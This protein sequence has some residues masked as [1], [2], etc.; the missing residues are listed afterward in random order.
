MRA[1]LLSLFLCT[2]AFVFAAKPTPVAPCGAGQEVRG[3]TTPPDNPA[4][5]FYLTDFLVVHVCNLNDFLA[6][7]EKQQQTVTLYLDGV[8]TSNP[9]VA[10]NR[11]EG[12]ITFVAD[13]NDQNKHLWRNW[14]YDPISMRREEMRV[15]IGHS[16]GRPLPRANGANMKVLL[17][18]IYVDWFTGMLVV[19]L[20][21][22]IV[23]MF[24]AGRHT[25]MLRDGPALGPIRQTYSLARTQMAWWFV[26]I[27]LGYVFVWLITS[28]RDT[29]PASLL[30]LMGISAATAVAAVA[31]EP[32]TGSRA[33]T[34]RA[35]LE[36]DIAAIDASLARIEASMTA[37]ASD[38]SLIAILEKKRNLQQRAR[39]A[40]VARS[41]SLTAV[42]PTRGFWRDL[43]TDDR[44]GVTLDRVQILVWTIVLGL[45]FLSSV[46]LELTMPEFSATM[47]ALMGISSGT[48]IGFKIPAAKKD[49]DEV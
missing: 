27:L 24:L 20:G 8:D 30:G 31:I 26:L 46:A 33:D 22:V 49:K 39:N 17:D 35:S 1:I 7:A 5:T 32:G 2:S 28:D 47:L 16:G 34:L 29:I 40:L 23:G 14:L 19:I 12:T 15:S 6:E 37:N 38:P 25:D 10:V 48:Y 41:A 36:S 44:G 11:E 42:V 18:K 45:I 13:R 4:R 9:H 21:G 43:V 3:V